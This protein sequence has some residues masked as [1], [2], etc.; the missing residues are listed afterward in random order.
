MGIPGRS[1]ALAIAARLGLKPEVIEQAKH[2]VGEATEDVNQVI[3][4]LEAQRRQQET[5]AAQAQQLLQQTE[6]LYRQ[7]SERTA[8][9]DARERELRASQ[10]QAI[11]QAIAQA[12]AEIAQVIRKLQQGTPTAQAAQQATVAIDRLAQQHTPPVPKPKA[13]FR[14][15]WRSHSHSPFRANRKF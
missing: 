5:K 9:L 12:K 3:A 7:L 10:E 14:P 4:G 11:Q 13:E 2:Q 8:Q 6:R 1:N 15:K